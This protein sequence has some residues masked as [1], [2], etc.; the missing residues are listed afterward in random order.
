MHVYCGLNF[1]LISL[2]FF[3]FTYLKTRALCAPIVRTFEQLKFYESIFMNNPPLSTIISIG[4]AIFSMLFGAGNLMYPL[5]VG[6]A[7]G[8]QTF[9]GFL[10]FIITAVCLP[11]LG[12]IS[13]ILFNGDY[14]DFFYRLGSWVGWSMIC[15]CMMIIGPLIVMPRLTTLSHTMISPFLPEFFSH[16]TPMASFIFA[17]IFLTITF[18]LTYKENRIVDVLGYVISPLLLISLAIIILKGILFSGSVTHTGASALTVFTENLRRGYET[19]DLLGALFFSSIIISILRNTLGKQDDTKGTLLITALKASFIGVSLLAL[20][21]IGM[22]MLGM[23]HGTGLEV[24]NAG[25]LFRAISFKILGAHGAAIIATAVLMACLSTAIALSAV[26]A[27]YLQHEIFKNRIGYLP[28]LIMVLISCLPLSVAGL[29]YVLSLT[30]GIITYV[31]YPVLIALTLA[32]LAYKL[33]GFTW[34][35]LPVFL[36]FIASLISYYY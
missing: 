30:G 32:N 26:V 1:K 11:V 10:G 8:D 3:F 7:A 12:F 21:Y 16:I 20:V 25:E 23:Y 31:G 29:T 2:C 17:L 35:K 34:V 4:L 22:S 28:S 14:K 33:A 19:L 13:M 6:M 18:V 36:V 24:I 5:Q 9:I 27:E 15:I